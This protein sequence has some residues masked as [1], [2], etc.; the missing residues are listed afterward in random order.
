MWKSIDENYEVSDAGEVRNSKTGKLRK[1]RLHNGYFDL[2]LYHKKR[3]VHRLV[4][5]A[6]LENPDNLHDVDHINS[7]KTDNRLENLRWASRSQNRQNTPFPKNNSS[8]I[9]GVSWHKSNEK[10][11][12]YLSIDGIKLHLGYFET[13]DAAKD[14]R[15]SKVSQVFTMPHVTEI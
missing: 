13:I 2:D 7:T 3:T 6:F 4:A 10:W 11:A 9:K 5:I 1:L 8:G 15:L 14:A 12:A